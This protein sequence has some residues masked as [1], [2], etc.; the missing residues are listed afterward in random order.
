MSGN[1]FG[2]INLN[3]HT[4]ECERVSNKTLNRKSDDFWQQTNPEINQKLL[5]LLW[6]NN[7]MEKTKAMEMIWKTLEGCMSLF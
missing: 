6:L 4:Y 1:Y 2:L 7:Y 5:N 3:N